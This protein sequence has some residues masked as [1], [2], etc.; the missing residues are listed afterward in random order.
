MNVMQ[1]KE[2]YCGEC[3][4]FLYEDADGFGVCGKTNKECYCGDK[5]HLTRKNHDTLRLRSLLQRAMFKVVRLSEVY[6]I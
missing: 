2:I 6:D 3:D 4:K 5:C 1:Y